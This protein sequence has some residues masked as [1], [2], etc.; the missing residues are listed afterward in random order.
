[1]SMVAVCWDLLIDCWFFEGVL[2]FGHV[3]D[4][5]SYCWCC[6]SAAGVFR[7]VVNLSLFSCGGD[8]RAFRVVLCLLVGC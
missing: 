8:V 1:M 2:S 4:W 3:L 6:V 7:C 5:D